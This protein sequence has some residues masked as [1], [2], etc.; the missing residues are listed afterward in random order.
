MSRAKLITLALAVAIF[1]AL[2][3]CALP[4]GFLV[5]P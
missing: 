4:L 3:G 2:S 1:W 5:F